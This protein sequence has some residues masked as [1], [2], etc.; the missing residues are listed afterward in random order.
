MSANRR[1]KANL[2]KYGVSAVVTS[3]YVVFVAAKLAL[4]HPVTAPVVV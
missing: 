2:V 1:T 3:V 4:L